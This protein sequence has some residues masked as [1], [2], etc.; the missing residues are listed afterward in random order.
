MYRIFACRSENKTLPVIEEIKAT[1]GNDKLEF[2]PIDLMSLKSVQAFITDFK[3]KYSQLHVLLNNAGLMG[4]SI[5]TSED[6]LDSQFATN[7]LAH[8]Y[9]TTQL[10]PILKRSDTSRVVNVSS[11]AH[12]FYVGAYD[13]EGINKIENHG[14]P[15]NYCTSKGANILFTIELSKRLEAQGIKVTYATKEKKY[16]GCSK[17]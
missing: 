4:A 8:F 6:G 16:I 1:T 13:F 2:I 11:L 9:L 3:S 14:A 7:H 12:K 15:N 17:T 5:K 10:L